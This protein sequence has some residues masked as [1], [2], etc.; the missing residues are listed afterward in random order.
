M[1]LFCFS[2]TVVSII[3]KIIN[4][5]G[6]TVKEFMFW[7]FCGNLLFSVT[8]LYKDKI[9]PFSDVATKGRMYWLN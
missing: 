5:Q 3:F 6:V 8:M 4:K 1:N 2:N 9:N 7:K